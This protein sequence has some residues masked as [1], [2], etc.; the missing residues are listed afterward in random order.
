MRLTKRKLSSPTNR[1]QLTKYMVICHWQQLLLISIMVGL[2]CVAAFGWHLRSIM[3]DDNIRQSII[4]ATPD[5]VEQLVVNIIFAKLISCAIMLPLFVIAGLG[6]G[7]GFYVMKVLLW[8]V[9]VSVWHDFF[10]GIKHNCKRLILLSVIGWFVYLI[11][12]VA[13]LY[14]LIYQNT[15]LWI[16]AQVVSVIMS[17]MVVLVLT[18]CISQTLVYN[19]PMSKVFSNACIMATTSF[20]GNIGTLLLAA[21]P[22]LI[23]LLTPD[24]VGNLTAFCIYFVFM[25]AFAILVLT[26]RT[27]Y[28][29]DK[30]INK[31]HY[32]Q[33]VNK[34]I[35]NH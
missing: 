31:E 35:S 6:I 19:L 23:V 27:H 21:A 7:G 12:N 14:V 17:S 1:V 4:D 22:L 8:E 18:F 26:L 3:V 20:W 11:T 33:L 15:T 24:L 29:F 30:L 34:G 2:F 5:T 16:I 9:N 28:I 32:P 13:T 25:F 10:V